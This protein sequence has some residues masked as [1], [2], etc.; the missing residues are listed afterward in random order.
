MEDTLRVMLLS[1][2]NS[3]AQV[4]ILILMEDTLRGIFSLTKM[5]GTKMS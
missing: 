4:L 1:M 2:N 3:N 5:C